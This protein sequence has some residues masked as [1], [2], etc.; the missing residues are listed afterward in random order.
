[1]DHIKN[2][3]LFIGFLSYLKNNIYSFFFLWILLSSLSFLYIHTIKDKYK[4][5]TFLEFSSSNSQ[6]N[7][8]NVLQLSLP[9]IS[10]DEVSNF[11]IAKHF[12]FSFNFFEVLLKDKNFVYQLQNFES[13]DPVK[14][15]DAFKI[16]IQKSELDD[17][18]KWELFNN[19]KGFIE[20]EMDTNGIAEFSVIHFSPNIST[21]W[22]SY[23]LNTLDN[24]IKSNEAKE[25][26]IKIDFYKKQYAEN[27]IVELNQ[28]LSD[29][30]IEEI[31][32]LSF[33][34]S[35][36]N[37]LYSV[38]DKTSTPY[39]KN[40]PNRLSLGLFAVAFVFLFLNFCFLIFFILRLNLRTIGKFV[41]IGFSKDK[42]N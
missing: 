29:L 4:S 36:D 28:S 39:M 8:T 33:M 32:K 2:E 9:G 26:N 7:F 19:F 38:L 14:R 23:I 27:N 37:F 42:N 21:D 6:N 30:L 31:K 13:F 22:N 10:N 17:K 1:M 35:T 24:F 40:Y 20:F 11:A 41:P 25:I 5:S 3:D 12:L 16:K 18:I 15:E 34:D